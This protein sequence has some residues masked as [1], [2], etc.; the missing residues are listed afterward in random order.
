MAGYNRPEGGWNY[1]YDGINVLEA[2]DALDP[3]QYPIAKNIRGLADRSVRTRPGYSLFSTS[4]TITTECPLTPGQ[5]DAIYSVT[6]AAVGGIPPYTWSIL[7]GTLPTG[8]SLSSGG[9][10]SGTP[11]VAGLFSFTVLVTDSAGGTDAVACSLYICPASGAGEDWIGCLAGA[12][13]SDAA[14]WTTSGNPLIA[15]NVATFSN[16]GGTG[17]CFNSLGGCG[18]AQDQEVYAIY[19]SKVNTTPGNRGYQ[20]QGIGVR[21]SGSLVSNYNGYF[22]TATIWGGNSGTTCGYAGNTIFTLYRIS[23]AVAVSIDSFSLAG[24]DLTNGI[25]WQ[26]SAVQEAGS[27]RVIATLGGTEIMNALDASPL[28]AGFPGMVN[29]STCGGVVPISTTWTFFKA[30]NL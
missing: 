10:L 7:T 6:F 18:S 8:L 22:M 30:R 12:S 19:G 16:V 27:A 26:L 1:V 2:P 24:P 20:N 17:F 3:R 21:V 4:P 14:D 15:S 29:Q 5:V 25:P 28:A 13:F 23:A 11:T 9:L